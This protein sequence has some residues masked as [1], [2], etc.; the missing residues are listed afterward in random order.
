MFTTARL[1]GHSINRLHDQQDSAQQQLTTIAAA[2]SELESEK[3][4]QD[5]LQ[6]LEQDASKMM[7]SIKSLRKRKRH[8]SDRAS[9]VTEVEQQAE[10]FANASKK[11][12]N[13]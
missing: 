5:L 7:E 13:V 1:A 8:H 4:E 12:K 2:I 11:L 3:R 6:S 10:A 9:M